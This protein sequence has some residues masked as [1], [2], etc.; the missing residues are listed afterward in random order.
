[1]FLPI[2]TAPLIDDETFYQAF[3]LILKHPPPFFYYFVFLA[4]I[5][6]KSTGRNLL[7]SSS[8]QA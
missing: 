4:R 2:E 1:M 8:F 3:F 6:Q 5:I 7:G